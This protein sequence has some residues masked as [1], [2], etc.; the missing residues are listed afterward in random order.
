MDTIVQF[1]LGLGAGLLLYLI[2]HL[3]KKFEGSFLALILAIVTIPCVC[4][5][6]YILYTAKTKDLYWPFVCGAG[7]VCFV[8][9]IYKHKKSSVLPSSD[10]PSDPP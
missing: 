10:E 1:I 9:E 2:L 4:Y 3:A 7:F 6:F 5:F 8:T